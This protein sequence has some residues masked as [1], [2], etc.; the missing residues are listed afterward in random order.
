MTDSHARKRWIHGVIRWLNRDKFI[1]LPE[2]PHYGLTVVRTKYDKLLIGFANLGTDVLNEIT[3]HLPDKKI[4]NGI[5]YLDQ[6]GIWK[7]AIYKIDYFKQGE[8]LG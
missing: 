6:D 5:K 3:F 2:N 1:V 4:L 7:E 8:K